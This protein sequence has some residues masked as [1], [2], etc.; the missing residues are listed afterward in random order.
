MLRDFRNT[1]KIAKQLSVNYKISFFLFF[2]T[3][4]FVNFHWTEAAAE[5]KIHLNRIW[6]TM[7]A[8][9]IWL[10]K[11]IMLHRQMTRML[12]FMKLHV[13]VTR[14][15]FVQDDLSQGGCYFT[16]FRVHWQTRVCL[17][18]KKYRLSFVDFAN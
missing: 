2:K 1:I 8:L 12:Y 17:E 13:W 4:C 7:Q 18:S 15:F 10:R 16:D 9:A 11:I 14:A 3:I 5:T 6:N